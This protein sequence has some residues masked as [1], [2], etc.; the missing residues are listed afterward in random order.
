MNS[1]GRLLA[2]AAVTGVGAVPVGAAAPAH[3]TWISMC[4]GA[5]QPVPL[6]KDERDRDCPGAC[7]AAC[8]RT[9]RYEEDDDGD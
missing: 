7:H 8:A 1:V 9:L 6:R 2:L 4:G 5:P 3:V